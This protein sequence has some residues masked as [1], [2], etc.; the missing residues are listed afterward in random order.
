MDHWSPL[1]VSLALI[2]TAGILA[3]SILLAMVLAHE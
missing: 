2:I 1:A 3:T